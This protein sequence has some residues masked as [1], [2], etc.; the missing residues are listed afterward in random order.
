MTEWCQKLF[1][2]YPK[3]I[4]RIAIVIV[5]NIYCIPTYTLW[6]LMLLPLKRFNQKLYYKIEGKFF[7]WLL[8][9]VAM[10]SWSAGYD[11]VESGD[12]L[13]PCQEEGTRTLIL[14]NHQ[15]TADVPLFMACFNA[16]PDVLPN[17]M[18]IMDRVFK[19]TNFGIVSVLHRD[20][21]VQAGRKTR[22][23]TVENLKHH[24]RD[25]FLPLERRWMVLFPEGG[26]LRKRLEVSQ[27]YAAKNNLP[28][29]KNVTLPRIGALKA[30]MEVIPPHNS[31]EH[32]FQYQSKKDDDTESPNLDYVLDVTVAYPD[33][34]TPLDLPTIVTGS[35]PPCKT[36]FLYRLYHSSE[37]PKDEQTLTQWLF[38]RWAE[39][40]QFLEE[41]YRTG[42]FPYASAYP[43]TVVEQ[44]LL[45]MLII[46]LFFI[47]STYVHYKLFYVITSLIL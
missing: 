2:V 37:I 17:I 29:L 46:N 20:F 24:L 32:I 43:P 14:A 21:F 30:I 16:K 35:R 26:F 27:K 45:R 42:D 8:S 4:V 13:T 7:H 19:F 38:D 3:A 34:G 39:K 44:D 5:N 41:F 31:I 22:D 6:M 40:E 36:H 1:I 28:M 11:V 9:V 25:T 15:S 18:W 10:W 33:N 12:D 47:T 23:A